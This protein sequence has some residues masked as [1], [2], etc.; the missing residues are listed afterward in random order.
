M[1]RGACAKGRYSDDVSKT[2]VITCPNGTYANDFTRHC[3][4][5]C[6]GTYFADPGINR[7][8]QICH[9]QDLYADVDSGN[10]CVTECNQTGATRF[11]DPTTKTCVSACPVDK[12]LFADTTAKSCVYNCT[13][14][15]Y[16]YSHVPANKRCMTA[17]LPPYFADNSTGYGVCITR[18]PEDP[19]L[20]GDVRGVD[21]LCV[22]V[23]QANFFGDQDPANGRL[24]VNPCPSGWFAQDDSLRRCVKRCNSTTYGHNLVCRL[25]SNC[26]PNWVGD[27]SKN[28]CV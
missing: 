12:Q 4:T 2:C 28:L 23:C 11:R 14:G 9:T 27:P 7:C 16:A 20:F 15:T 8:V 26:P 19:I 22:P 3:E 10:K 5:G 17:C 24:C 18:C 21:R 25:P 1:A 6:S 13:P